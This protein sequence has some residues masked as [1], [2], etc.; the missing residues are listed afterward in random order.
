LSTAED[1][2]DL[3]KKAREE[4]A[5]QA[6]KKLNISKSEAQ[7]QAEKLI[8]VT[9]DVG[10]INM[11]RGRGYEEKHLIEQTKKIA[12]FVKHV[13]LSDNFGLEHTELP[14]GMGN[15]P[16]KKMLDLIHEYNKKVK[17]IVETGDWFQPFKTTPFRE[18]LAAF[19][20]PTYGIDAPYWNQ[21]GY[22]SGSYFAGQGA[23]NPPIHHSIWGSGFSNLP[24][25]LGGQMAGRS[26]VSGAPIE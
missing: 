24:I 7:K 15:V 21:I 11:L 9:W 3:V 8:G 2:R 25:E 17:K 22:A 14:M 12:P 5:E 20:S 16:T 23:T 13:H 26:R 4:F 10:H 19:G 18:T 1:L 6:V